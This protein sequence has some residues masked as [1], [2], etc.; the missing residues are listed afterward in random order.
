[1]NG[2]EG[3]PGAD[4]SIGA[5]GEPG[6]E[7]IPGQDG[8]DGVRGQPGEKGARGDPGEDGI[9]GEPGPQG[10]QGRQ[11]CMCCVCVRACVDNIHFL[12]MLDVFCVLEAGVACCSTVWCVAEQVTHLSLS[13]NTCML[14][15]LD[16]TPSSTIQVY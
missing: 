15:P 5:S 8:P 2:P 1:M 13:T 6:N 14:G 10:Q 16:I 11:V 3:A 9:P 12:V 7:G 4:G